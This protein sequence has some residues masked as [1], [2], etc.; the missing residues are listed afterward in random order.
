MIIHGGVRRPTLGNIEPFDINK[1]EVGDEF[2]PASWFEGRP[3]FPDPYYI[4]SVENG[5]RYYSH[6]EFNTEV[7]L[8]SARPNL[9]VMRLNNRYMEYDPTQQG[10]TDED[11]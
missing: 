5:S 2:A 6:K 4:V 7:L 8:L 1:L 10:D 3:N 11:I 9:Y